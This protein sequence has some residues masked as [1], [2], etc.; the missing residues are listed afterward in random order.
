MIKL[1]KLNYGLEYDQTKIEFI[2]DIYINN[3]NFKGFRGAISYITQSNEN[4]DIL[5]SCWDGNVYLFGKFECYFNYDK[6]VI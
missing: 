4:R 5:I 6:Q 1:Y 2:H 3:E